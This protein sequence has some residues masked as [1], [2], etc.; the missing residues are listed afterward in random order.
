MK[1]K[2]H[3]M[4]VELMSD[5]DA[6]LWARERKLMEKG[7]KKLRVNSPRHHPAKRHYFR[8]SCL[9]TN[10]SPTSTPASNKPYYTDRTA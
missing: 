3:I 9:V 10:A 1:V 2:K 5:I 7:K 6:S 4:R 8:P